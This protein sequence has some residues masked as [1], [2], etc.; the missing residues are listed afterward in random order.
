MTER[1]TVLSRTLLVHP[2]SAWGLGLTTLSV[3]VF[4]LLWVV[5]GAG[6][7][8]NP[9]VGLI[10]FVLLP[11]LAGVG[12]L[13][14]G[15]G[16]WLAR[17]RSRRGLPDYTWPTWNLHDPRTR[18]RVVVLVVGIVTGTLLAGIASIEAVHSMDSPEFCGQ[19][20]HT[21]MTPHFIQWQAGAAHRSVACATCHIGTGADSVL[22]AKMRGTRQ[23]LGVVT[24]S[25][26]RPIPSPVAHRPPADQTCGSCHSATAWVGERRHVYTTFADDEQNTSSQSAMA[27]LVGGTTPDGGATG[28]HWHASPAVEIEYLALDE[29]RDTIP[30]VRVRTPGGPPKDYVAEG[31]DPAAVT[32]EWRRMDC[33]DCHNRTAHPFAEDPEQVVD[34]AMADGRLDT[35]LPFVRREAVRL[36]TAEYPSHEE[37]RAAIGTAME[38][39]YAAGG[40]DGAVVERDWVTRAAAEVAALRARYVFPEMRVTFGTYP[41]QSGHMNA[42]G[43]F[44]CHDEQH[45]AADGSTIPQQCDSCHRD[46]D[47]PQLSSA[48]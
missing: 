39:L 26:P 12:L 6:W 11:A 8:S 13:L 47:V 46:E 17:R 1:V 18:G 16:I 44:R 30:V 19:V 23:L 33:V 48:W 9:Y 34:R 37:A 42:P 35:R 22:D 27:L 4:L 43:C 38:T 20:C 15:F 2:L 10:T 36:L 29:T 7:L 32:G 3:V 25:Y 28:I 5:E 24:G 21:P 31:F 41:S 45:V 14:A 40:A